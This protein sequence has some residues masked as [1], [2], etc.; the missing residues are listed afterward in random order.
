MRKLQR[1]H[2]RHNY[3]TNHLNL[4]LYPQTTIGAPVVVAPTVVWF[5]FVLFRKLRYCID[6]CKSLKFV[7]ILKL[8]FETIRDL[9]I[10]Q[11][12]SYICSI[13]KWSQIVTQ[14]L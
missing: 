10:L 1:L 14:V 8:F 2:Y 12:N 4:L 5:T 11:V 9:F 3:T 6:F 13:K 7:L